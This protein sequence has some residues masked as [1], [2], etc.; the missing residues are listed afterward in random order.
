MRLA[1]INFTRQ[2]GDTDDHRMPDSSA[3][4]K[5]NNK[6]PF[7]KEEGVASMALNKVNSYLFYFIRFVTNNNLAGDS[8]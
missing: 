5:V 2:K 1:N 7:E 4:D 6:L 3:L 8:L